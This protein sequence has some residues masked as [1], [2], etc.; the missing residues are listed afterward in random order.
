VSIFLIAALAIFLVMR[1][2]K[3]GM[4]YPLTAMV[5][6]LTRFGWEYLRYYDES[7]KAY[8]YF[9]GFTFWQMMAMIVFLASAVWILVMKLFGAKSEGK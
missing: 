5:Y 6:S 2:K 9:F 1:R 8:T 3:T 4:V 7:S